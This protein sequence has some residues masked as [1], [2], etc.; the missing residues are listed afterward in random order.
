MSS[1]NGIIR[2]RTFA[3][4]SFA[5]ILKNLLNVKKQQ[6]LLKVLGESNTK[7]GRMLIAISDPQEAQETLDKNEVFQNLSEM[8]VDI[9]LGLDNSNTVDSDTIQRLQAIGESAKAFAEGIEKIKGEDGVVQ[10]NT[11]QALLSSLSLFLDKLLLP[12]L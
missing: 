2:S 8:L 6:D 12:P 5:K 7:L 4:L 10:D 3:I 1:S 9:M 11:R